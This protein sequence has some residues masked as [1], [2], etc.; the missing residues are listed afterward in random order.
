[1]SRKKY[2]VAILFFVI[3]LFSIGPLVKATNMTV[4]AA[5]FLVMLFTIA[6]TI[7]VYQR[8]AEIGYSSWLILLTFLPLAGI[9]YMVWIAIKNPR[10]IEMRKSPSSLALFICIVISLMVIFGYFFNRTQGL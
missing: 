8:T 5:M 6:M 2:I 4:D 9:I 10:P 3:F 1:M 7:V